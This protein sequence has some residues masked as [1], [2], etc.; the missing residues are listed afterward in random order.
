M[1]ERFLKN[2]ISGF[3]P[4]EMLEF[5][6]FF[7]IPRANTNETGH[8]LIDRFGSL[9]E[10]MKASPDALCSVEGV[11][12]SSAILI[13]FVGQLAPYCLRSDT[14]GISLATP[15]ERCDFFYPILACEALEVVKLACLDDSL[16]LVH[17]ADIAT[18]TPGQVTINLQQMLRVMLHSHCTSFVLA[19]NH[20]K[21]TAFPSCDDSMETQHI[22][23]TLEPFDLHLIDHVIVGGG[24]A[25]SMYE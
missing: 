3:Q 20:P 25:Y 21:G 13:H 4:H 9:P 12:K 10:V 7:S 22:R 17:V 1:R 18:G 24:K 16:R 6:L 23:K 2:G 8:A 5:L 14:S 15:Q 11:G 19:H